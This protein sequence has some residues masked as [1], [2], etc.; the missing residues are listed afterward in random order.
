M[1]FPCLERRWH[2]HPRTEGLPEICY[3][4]PSPGCP[5]S[6]TSDDISDNLSLATDRALTGNIMMANSQHDNTNTNTITITPAQLEKHNTQQDLWVAVYGNVYNL[7]SFAADH[8]GGIDVLKD[9][10]G[11]DGSKTYEYAGH[12]AYAMK[13]MQQFLVGR[14]AESTTTAT[15]N[16]AH[17]PAAPHDSS[18]KM[19][20]SSGGSSSSS[21]KSARSITAT[22]SLGT[23]TRVPLLAAAAVL[24]VL[25]GL[26]WYFGAEPE[27]GRNVQNAAHA[28]WAGLLIA[29]LLSCAGFAVLYALFSK[30]LE[31]EKDVFSYPPVMPRAKVV[32]GV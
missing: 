2:I 30:T 9:C 6:H 5:R 14:L 15:T 19:N 7:T 11:T 12:S 8:P 28:F 26:Y 27:L 20:G 21:S 22:L 10:A 23:W 25:A 1:I 16:P 29:S 31:H 18:V 3:G 13:T 17:V 4:S 24:S 32:V